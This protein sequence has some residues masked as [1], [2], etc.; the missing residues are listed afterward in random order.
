MKRLILLALI[1]SQT[2]FA[3]CNVNSASQLATQRKVGPIENLTKTISMGICTV[4]FDITVDGVPHHLTETEKGLEQEESLCYYAK[5]RARKNLL[6]DL[7]GT[8][9]AEAITTCLEGDKQPTRVKIGDIILA[10][11]VKPSPIKKDFMHK[12]TKC[13][14]FQEHYPVDRQLRIYN[15]VMCQTDNDEWMVVDKW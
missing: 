14:M 7:G 10:T 2:A 4:N 11:Q 3:E 9:K 1:V 6:L 13:R 5:E 8:F 12:G 15:G